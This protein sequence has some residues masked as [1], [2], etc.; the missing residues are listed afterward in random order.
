MSDRP[1]AFPGRPSLR[2][3]KIEATRRLAAGEFGTLHDPQLAIARE[4]GLPSRTALK[5][6]VSA[7][8]HAL[9][10]VRWVLA[11]FARATEPAGRRHGDRPRAAQPHRRGGQLVV[12]GALARP[13][14]RHGLPAGR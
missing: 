3:L 12:P 14:R 8:G 13:G 6:P 7:P 1:R 11:R 5:E 4:H 10:Q 2:F 9:T